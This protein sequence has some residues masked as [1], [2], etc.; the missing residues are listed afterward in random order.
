MTLKISQRYHKEKEK[1]TMITDKIPQQKTIE[2]NP[3]N[4]KT[5]IYY[6]QVGFS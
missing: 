1:R 2:L 5:I 3:T 6:N 4:M